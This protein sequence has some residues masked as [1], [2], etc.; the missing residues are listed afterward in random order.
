[1]EEQPIAGAIEAE[2]RRQDNHVEGVDQIIE[3]AKRY[4]LA[5][6]EITYPSQIEG[7]GKRSK[8]I[9][10]RDVFLLDSF[11]SEPLGIFAIEKQ[12][13][14]RLDALAKLSSEERAALGYDPEDTLVSILSREGAEA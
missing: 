9:V 4:G 10:R 13:R 7:S 14:T 8:P 2:L 3:T 5:V 11:F 6:T 12:V 1:M